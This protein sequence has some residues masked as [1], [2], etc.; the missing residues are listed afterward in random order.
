MEFDT[1]AIRTI[2]QQLFLLKTKIC[3]DFERIFKIN[4]NYMLS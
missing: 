3:N 4:Q 1:G 2:L